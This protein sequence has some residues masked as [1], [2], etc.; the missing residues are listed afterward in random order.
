MSIIVKDKRLQVII[1]ILILVAFAVLIGTMVK[2]APDT[3]KISLLLNK[4]SVKLEI[5]YG[6]SLSKEVLSNKNPTISIQP[7]YFGL[8]YPNPGSPTSLHGTFVVS[9]EN[10]GSGDALITE[11]NW[12]ILDGSRVITPPSEWSKIIGQPE[13]RNF[14]LPSASGLI[15]TYGPEITASGKDRVTLSIEVKYKD[16]GKPELPVHT[17][18]YTGVLNY[19]KGIKVNYSGNEFITINTS[20]DL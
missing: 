14:T 19:D 12:K 17:A 18:Y 3:K 10:K 8:S 11:I 9:I 2:K 16:I 13:L 5:E 20:T 6:I 1:T 4:D 7:R 15:Y